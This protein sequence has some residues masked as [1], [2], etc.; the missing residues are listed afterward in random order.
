MTKQTVF[1]HQRDVPEVDL[2]L[3]DISDRSNFS[4]GVFVPHDQPD[5]HLK[6]NGKGHPPLLALVQVVFEVQ[7]DRITTIITTLDFVWIVDTTALTSNGVD[8]VGIQDQ[9]LPTLLTL[10]PQML[11]T[12]QLATLTLP[13]A[14]RVLDEFQRRGPAKVGNRKNR[15][16][17]RLQTNIL[18][19]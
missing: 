7:L 13:V 19:L 9:G 5:G 15:I 16:E 8:G 17:H 12:I 3:L 6:R 4:V 10:R 11:E 2:L 1:R 18:T 14:D